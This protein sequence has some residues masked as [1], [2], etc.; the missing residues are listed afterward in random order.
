M[1]SKNV[2]EIQDGLRRPSEGCNFI[3]DFKDEIKAILQ[4]CVRNKRKQLKGGEIQEELPMVYPS[5]LD[6]PSVHSIN[7]FVNGTLNAMVEAGD[8]VK[9]AVGGREAREMMPV[10]Y[11][12]AI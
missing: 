6:I 11:V 10:R 3:G 9:D 12:D 2:S 8:R 5:R 7:C 1:L 4:R